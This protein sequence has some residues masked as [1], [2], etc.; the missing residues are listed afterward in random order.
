LIAKTP[1]D[2]ILL[3]IMMPDISGIDVLRELRR[4]YNSEILPILMV[5]AKNESG[6]IVEALELGANDY[7]SKP[8]DFPVVVARIH[9]LLRNKH[10]KKSQKSEPT[11][12]KPGT[13]LQNKYR[14]DWKIGI[15]L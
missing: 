10:P 13:I 11:L 6:D 3:D 5:T 4:T 7:V 1:I 15:G 2:L 9:A 12:I 8:I 14:L